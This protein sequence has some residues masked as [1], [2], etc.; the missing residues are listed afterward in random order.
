VL[1]DILTFIGEKDEEEA[2][3]ENEKE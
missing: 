3:K 2:S 1:W